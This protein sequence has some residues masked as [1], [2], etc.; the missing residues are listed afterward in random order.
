MVVNEALLHNWFYGNLYVR[1]LAAVVFA[2]LMGSI[3]VT[4]IMHWLFA[5]VDQRIARTAVALAP[6]VNTVKAAIPV[7][8]AT[9]GGGLGVG[10]LAAVGVVAGHTYCPWRRFDGGTGV[11]AELGAL[12]GVCWPA[13]IVYFG[14]WVTVAAGSNYAV[15]GSLTAAA[16]TIVSL[17]FFAGAPA[18][19]AGVAM[20]LLVA[21]RFHNSY[22]RLSEGTEPT[23]RNPPV[24]AARVATMVP[25]TSVV[26]DGQAVQRV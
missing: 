14:V 1:E 5:G 13:A 26:V 8:I 15:A 6:V 23:L 9:H 4:P 24:P 25:R 17:W 11:A 16:I 22:A 10:L 18:A 3:P 20:L 21:S 12:I 7:A 2:V 19:F